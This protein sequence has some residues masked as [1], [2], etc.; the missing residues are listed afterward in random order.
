MESKQNWTSLNLIV[1][2]N[3]F[4]EGIFK[5]FA[6]KAVRCRRLLGRRWQMLVRTAMMF[7]RKNIAGL[8][9]CR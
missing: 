3:P 4:F 9:E 8:C 1:W 5:L 6:L 7:V 2:T